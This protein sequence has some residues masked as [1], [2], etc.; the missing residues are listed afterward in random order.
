MSAKLRNT[1]LASG[2][3]SADRRGLD[4]SQQ[5]DESLFVPFFE[6]Q[7]RKAR[8]AAAIAA[9]VHDE[10]DAGD[11]HLRNHRFGHAYQDGLHFSRQ[12]ELASAIK[13]VKRRTFFW[14]SAG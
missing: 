11:T 1:G 6:G 10:F 4:T 2:W 3:T 14:Q 12:V 8:N 9:L 5:A 13:F 7:Q